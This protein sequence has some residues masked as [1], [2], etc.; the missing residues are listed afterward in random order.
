MM[1][2]KRGLRSCK[3]S[4]PFMHT[5][6]NFLPRFFSFLLFIPNL[7]FILESLECVLGPSGNKH[8]LADRAR[9]PSSIFSRNCESVGHSKCFQGIS[10]YLNS[11][12]SLLEA[13]LSHLS[14][15]QNGATLLEDFDRFFENLP[16]WQD[17]MVL[18]V[19][20]SST[21]ST[22]SSYSSS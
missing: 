15:F 10:Q 3:D 5:R 17:V 12:C 11:L 18:L 4:I 2:R 1:V 8:L 16:R 9:S 20:S 6:S 21:S 22:S 7:F 14:G 19:F 13:I